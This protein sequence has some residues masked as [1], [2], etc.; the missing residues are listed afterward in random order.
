M[1]RYQQH[2][3]LVHRATQSLYDQNNPGRWVE[4]LV[5]C[6]KVNR[7]G[8]AHSVLAYEA[9]STVTLGTMSHKFQYCSALKWSEE[10]PSMC[11]SAG[12]LQLPPFCRV[13]LQPGNVQPPKHIHFMDRAGKYN[14]WFNMTSF[15]A[16]VNMSQCCTCQHLP[17]GPEDR[18]GESSSNQQE[19]WSSYPCN[20]KAHWRSWWLLECT[21]IKWS[22][23]GDCWSAIQA[24]EHCAAE[25][26]Q[27]TM[28]HQQD[29]QIVQRP[30]C[31]FLFCHVE[32]EY[33]IALPQCDPET[34][35]PLK[36]TVSTVSFYSYC[37]ISRQGEVNH[38]YFYSFGHFVKMDLK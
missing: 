29:P 33:S 20:L 10:A 18:P 35:L 7:K 19:D 13:S 11:C 25:P 26:W 3:P 38:M 5:Q 4:S 16:H 30:A 1:A 12:K 36:K 6:W 37:I 9:D 31:L 2:H 17:K 28:V 24:A 27:H 15:A 14:G 32:D 23:S 22:S 34:K 21:N 8:K